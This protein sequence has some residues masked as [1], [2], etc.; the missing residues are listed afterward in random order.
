M[1]ITEEN[2]QNNIAQVEY[3][4]AQWERQKRNLQIQCNKYRLTKTRHLMSKGFTD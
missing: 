2:K 3:C 1:L 4:C